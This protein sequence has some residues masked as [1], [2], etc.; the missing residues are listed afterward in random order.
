[1]ATFFLLF[2]AR[3]GIKEGLVAEGQDA[4]S[5]VFFYFFSF[6]LN[7]ILHI[8]P[9][10]VVLSNCKDYPATKIILLFQAQ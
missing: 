6:L 8:S 2:P 3:V 10:A 5:F 1:M 7:V 4:S 9:V